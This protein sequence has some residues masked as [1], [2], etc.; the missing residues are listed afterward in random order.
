MLKTDIQ[1]VIMLDCSGSTGKKISKDDDVNNKI[2]DGNISELVVRPIG[3]IDC[4]V[5]DKK[6]FLNTEKLFFN[7]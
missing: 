5:V 6:D 2:I 7:T 1:L 4:P 3:N